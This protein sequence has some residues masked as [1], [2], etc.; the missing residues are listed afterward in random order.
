MQKI[1]PCLWFDNQGEEAM[2]FYMSIF[3]GSKIKSVLRNGDEGPGPKGSILTA[4][5]ILEGQE[6][7]V[8]NGGPLFKF[9]EAISLSINCK[10][11]KEID[12]FWNK[13]TNGGQEQ[14][15]G[16]LKHKYGLS[17]QVVPSSLGK[18]MIDKNEKKAKRV[19]TALFKMKKIDLNVL[20][21]EYDKK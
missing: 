14:P 17:W 13:L 20:K 9:N 12:Y 3:K 11:Q 7:I 21:K 4:S 19:M 2:N 15:C 8:L 1:T 5:F 18:M 10:T 16:W 6:F